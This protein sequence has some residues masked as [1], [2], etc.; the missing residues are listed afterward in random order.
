MLAKRHDADYG[1]PGRRHE[2]AGTMAARPE[3]ASG[4]R[5]LQPVALAKPWGRC[6]PGD[7]ALA[8]WGLGLCR[9]EPIGEIHHSQPGDPELLVKT[10]FTAERLSVQVHPDDA[11]ARAAGWARG[12]DEAWVVLAADPGATIGIGPVRAADTAELRAGALDGGIV[13]LLHWHPCAVGDVFFTP[14]GTIHAIGAGVTL[15][16]IQQNLDVTYRLFDYGRGR[17]LHLDAGL[18]V[19]CPLPWQ[20][21]PVR[22][23]PGPGRELLVEGPSFL[24]ER[25]LGAGVLRPAAAV[26]IAVVSGGGRIGGMDFAAGDVLHADAETLVEG[27][28]E[29]LLAYAGGQAQHDLWTAR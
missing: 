12:K 13:E 26:W 3:I 1:A 20:R 6:G 22:P 17:E 23:S 25:V 28:G 19:A 5:R 7:P 4:V 18:A 16:E 15:F 2:M 14:A 24:L 11:A 27:D 8:T 10:L 9:D 29:L 21:Q